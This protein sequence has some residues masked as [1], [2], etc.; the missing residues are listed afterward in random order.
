MHNLTAINKTDR[1][2]SV[3]ITGITAIADTTTNKNVTL[4]G[5]SMVISFVLADWDFLETSWQPAPEGE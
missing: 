4:G 1:S 5:S 2:V 3:L